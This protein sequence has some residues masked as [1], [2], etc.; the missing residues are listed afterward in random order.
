MFISNDE[1]YQL[2]I[3]LSEV[4]TRVIVPYVETTFKDLDGFIES[5]RR[6]FKN[7]F[8]NFFKKSDKSESFLF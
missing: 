2:G 7:S 4:L 1:V 3:F 6:G 8:K 5:K